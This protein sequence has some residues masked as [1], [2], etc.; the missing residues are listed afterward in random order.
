M[1]YFI[2]YFSSKALCLFVMSLASAIT[3]RAEVIPIEP[4]EKGLFI[5]SQPSMSMYWQGKNSK[6]VLIFIPGGEGYIRLKPGQADNT[7]H[8]HQM[9][10]RL[11]N[12]TLTSGTFDAVLLDSPYELSPRQAYPPARG[13]SDHLIRIE[14]AVRYYKEKTG[15]PVW[16]MGHSNGGISLTEFVKHMQNENKLNLVAGMIASGIRSESYFNAPLDMPVLFMH[17]KQDGCSHTLPDSSYSI[18][19]KVKEFNKSVTEFVYVTEGEP[20][21]KDPCR[22]GFHMYYGASD[23]AA[24]I[25]DAF[26][27][28]I[29]Q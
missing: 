29:Y 17:H 9:L 5:S 27:S 24:K 12:P 16:L 6:A 15:L 28:K 10:K 2:K 21:S 11:T 7:F 14:S 3:A 19:M 4:I 18:Y 25:I 20:D 22:S 23:E 13:G 8:F 1:K 26:M